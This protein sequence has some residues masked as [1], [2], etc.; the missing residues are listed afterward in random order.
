MAF[1]VGTWVWLVSWSHVSCRQMLFG[2]VLMSKTIASFSLQGILKDL[3][4]KLLWEC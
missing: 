4:N 1:P 2:E 3:T